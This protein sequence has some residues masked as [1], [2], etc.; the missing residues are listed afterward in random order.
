MTLRLNSLV[1][2]YIS[3]ETLLCSSAISY[4][5]ETP[6][7]RD[8]LKKENEREARTYS[9]GFIFVIAMMVIGI[10]GNLHVLLVYTFRAKPSNR[11]IFI[12][13][14][15]TL[16]LITCVVGMPFILM[17]LRNPLTFK[18]TIVCKTFRL[19]NY[20]ICSASSFILIVI[21]S[22]R[23]VPCIYF[24]CCYK[25]FLFIFNIH[26]FFI[27]NLSQKN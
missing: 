9:G 24:I 16:D 27:F 12:L 17:D 5:M 10:V 26:F 13:V 8:F 6:E 25:L 19:N 3:Q 18:L 11:R 2:I 21:A 7:I 23:Y 4:K 20:F 22:D 14:L 15:G 1:I